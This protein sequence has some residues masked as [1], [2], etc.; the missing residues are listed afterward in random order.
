[1]WQLVSRI[2]AINAKSKAVAV[3]GSYGWSGEGIPAIIARLRALNMN[4]FEEGCKCR[5]VPSEAELEAAYDY[6]ARFAGVI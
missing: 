4:V 2:D 5:L 3:F 6:G 1:M